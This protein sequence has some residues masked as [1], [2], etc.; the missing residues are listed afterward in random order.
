[1]ECNSWNYYTFK[2]SKRTSKLPTQALENVSWD[3][4]M[5]KLPALQSDA[6]TAPPFMKEGYYHGVLEGVATA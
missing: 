2:L 3:H 4:Y 5:F 1:M 6:V